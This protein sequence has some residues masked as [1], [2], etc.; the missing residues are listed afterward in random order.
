MQAVL[1]SKAIPWKQA[2]WQAVALLLLAALSAILTNQGRKDSLPLIGN[3]S[4][5]ARYSDTAGQSLV[6]SLKEARRMFENDAALFID[7][8]SEDLY[9]EGHI[10][11]ALNLPWQEVD[12]F[13]AELSDRLGPEKPLIAYC[14]GE[15]CELSHELAL[16]LQDMGFSNVRVLVNGWTEWQAAGLPTEKGPNKP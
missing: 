16:F 14:D 7:A 2:V 9:T 11:G 15:S 8:R 3:W 13:Y 10:R 5:E 4:A 6:V 1:N 12:R